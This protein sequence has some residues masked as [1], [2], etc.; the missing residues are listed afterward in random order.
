MKSTTLSMGHMLGCVGNEGFEQNK[1]VQRSKSAQK[2]MHW[3]FCATPRRTAQHPWAQRPKSSLQPR[4]ETASDWCC[5][6]SF[7]P[8]DL[9]PRPSSS[10]SALA[11][12]RQ[13][14]HSRVRSLRGSKHAN[15][16]RSEWIVQEIEY[17]SVNNGHAERHRPASTTAHVDG[18]PSHLLRA[19]FTLGC[20]H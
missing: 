15:A 6:V 10:G 14:G 12:S 5:R 11:A 16:E 3:T 20:S 9:P 13:T 8:A 7:A 2:S 4:H 18:H 1:L 19:H 17:F